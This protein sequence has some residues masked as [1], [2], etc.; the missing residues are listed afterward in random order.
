MKV[1]Y[2][3]DVN[4]SLEMGKLALLNTGCDVLT[5][6]NGN[7]AFKIASSERPDLILT[8]LYMPEMN[9]DELCE[10]IRQSPSLGKTPVVVITFVDDSETVERCLAAGCNEVM[11]K[12]YTKSILI[13]IVNKYIN[14][15]CRKYERYP[16]DI[17][18]AFSHD[19]KVISGKVHDI[20]VEGMFVRGEEAL[21]VGT[22]TEFI[23]L[24]GDDS[25]EID[26][27]GKIVR[28]V[29]GQKEFAFDNVPGMGVQFDHV[30]GDLRCVI[31]QYA[32]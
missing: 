3:D 28:L 26:V 14:I 30:P 15:I 31:D 22:E 19:G 20:S 16:V 13:G 17:D 23:L 5:A 21:P 7:E 25:G 12:P 10:K 4:L 24:A 32:R 29:T 6:S 18:V 9:G 2:V 8:D 27:K 1:L 11:K